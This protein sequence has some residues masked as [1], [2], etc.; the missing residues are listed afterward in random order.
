MQTQCSLEPISMPA[1]SGL[2]FS[3]ASWM[4]VFPF[5]FS[6]FDV[7][8][9]IVIV[10]SAQEWHEELQSFKQ[11]SCADFL[12]TC[13]TYTNESAENPGTKLLRG[14]VNNTNHNS[15]KPTN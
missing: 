10:V 8:F 1:A 5:S 2:I 15:P 12:R 3:Q 13:A 6:D 11:D 4:E 9:F 7:F 14:H